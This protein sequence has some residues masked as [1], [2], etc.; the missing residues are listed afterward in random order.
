MAIVGASWVGVDR[1]FDYVS[2]K[3]RI[4]VIGHHQ[5][6]VAI[7][8]VEPAVLRDIGQDPAVVHADAG[9]KDDVGNARVGWGSLANRSSAPPL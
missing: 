2:R 4:A 1:G 5:R 6:D 7:F 3:A 9:L 8:T